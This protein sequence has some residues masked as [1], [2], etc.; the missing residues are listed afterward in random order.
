MRLNFNDRRDTVF[1]LRT[2]AADLEQQ[3][4]VL[5][6]GTRLT[7]HQPSRVLVREQA[8]KVRE[9]AKMLRAQARY[10]SKLEL[11]Y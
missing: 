5:Q 6:Q 2:L 8:R 9:S 1:Q 4:D 3:A 11:S 7:P 10:V